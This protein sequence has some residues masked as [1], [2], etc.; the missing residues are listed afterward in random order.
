MLLMDEQT[1]EATCYFASPKADVND[2]IEEVILLL[3]PETREGLR[4]ELKLGPKPL[5]A[6][7]ESEQVFGAAYRVLRDI[8]KQIHTDSGNPVAPFAVKI[9]TGRLNGYVFLNLEADTIRNVHNE[10]SRNHRL[11]L[12][13]ENRTRLQERLK[14]LGGSFDII[15][16]YDVPGALAYRMSI[17]AAM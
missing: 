5:M 15:S 6:H 14:R 11:L 4:I 2:I 1:E 9:T 13:F 3:V 10:S 17:P 16:N 8:R 12:A 7:A